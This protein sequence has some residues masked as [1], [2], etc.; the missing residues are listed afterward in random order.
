M[1]WVKDRT[2]PTIIFGALYCSFAISYGRRRILH[3]NITKH[4]TSLWVVR[5]LRESFPSEL[6]PRF[7]IF[8]R[9]AKCGLGVPVAVKLSPVQLG[10]ISI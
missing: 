5:Q 6:A 4:P 8:E 7:L 1:S 10:P 3:R 9:D 2:V